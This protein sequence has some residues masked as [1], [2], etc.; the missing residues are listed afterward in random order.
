MSDQ[1][2]VELCWSRSEHA[3][4]KMA[5][6]YG[7]YCYS[8]AF[9]ILVNRE[10]AEE[11]VNDTYLAAW[12]TIPPKR[13]VMLST[14]LG[15]LTRRISIDRL[16]RRTADKRG[17]GEIDLVLEELEYCIAGNQNMESDY[18]HKELAATI[19]RFLDTLP[20][21]ERNVFLCRYWYLD[22]VIDIA[23]YFDFSQS[24]VTSMLHRIRRKL[25]T[26][27]EREGYL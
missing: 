2:I 10:D 12:S 17:G 24:K 15:K 3:V 25:R 5:E 19:N 4:D 27:L 11:S 6:K 20:Q 7:S 26:Q 21:T 16:R 8:I 13:P 23:S 18:I 22:S 1:E 14:F 9:N